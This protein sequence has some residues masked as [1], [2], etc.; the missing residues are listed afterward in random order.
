MIVSNLI[1]TSV[2]YNDYKMIIE[3]NVPFILFL[4][5]S[6]E[7]SEEAHLYFDMLRKEKVCFLLMAIEEQI[8]YEETNA[9]EG[10]D[11]EKLVL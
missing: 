10:I 4:N 5:D 1:D 7:F 9:G 6:Y 2:N 3:I 8:V 11:I